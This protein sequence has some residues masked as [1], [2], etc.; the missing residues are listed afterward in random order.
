[1]NKYLLYPFLLLFF[2][3]P[4]LMPAQGFLRMESLSQTG[5]TYLDFSPADLVKTSKGF[6][7][8]YQ[9][10]NGAPGANKPLILR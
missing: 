8:T 7:A 6:T 2:S 1:M 10:H 4:L 3:A 5:L 9:Y